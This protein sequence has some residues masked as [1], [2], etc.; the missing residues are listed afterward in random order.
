MI[1][2]HAAI[3]PTP[4]HDCFVQCI[5]ELKAVVRLQEATASEWAS[6][7]QAQMDTNWL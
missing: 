1:I 6:V 5:T 3:T 2:R 4:V 7:L